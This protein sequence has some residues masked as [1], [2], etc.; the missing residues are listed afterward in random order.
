[1][2]PQILILLHNVLLQKYLSVYNDQ[3]GN[4]L[5]PHCLE[6]S[7]HLY[8]AKVKREK[9]GFSLSLIRRLRNVSHVEMELFTDLSAET[10]RQRRVLDNNVVICLLVVFPKRFLVQPQ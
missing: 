10:L 2:H 8:S 4:V 9:V 1:M 7:L 3:S 6:S 5:N